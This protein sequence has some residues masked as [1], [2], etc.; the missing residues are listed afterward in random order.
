MKQTTGCCF[1]F[2]ICQNSSQQQL[3]NPIKFNIRITNTKSWKWHG[4]F[5]AGGL[6]KASKAMVYKEKQNKAD[7]CFWPVRYQMTIKWIHFI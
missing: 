7:I 1:L 6:Q 3:S 2:H 4:A 5:N